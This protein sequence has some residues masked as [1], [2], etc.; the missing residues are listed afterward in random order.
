[1]KLGTT[2]EQL[3]DQALRERDHARA[4]ADRLAWA[5]GV[6]LDVS[7]GEHGRKFDDLWSSARDA[8]RAAAPP[9]PPPASTAPDQA[10]APGRVYLS[11]PMTG[12][13]EHNV[14]AFNAQARRLR[15]AGYDVVNPA[16]VNPDASLSWQQCLRQDMALLPTCDTL[17]LLPGWEHSDGAHLELHVAHRLGLRIVRVDELRMGGR[18][19]GH[20]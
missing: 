3:A 8:I 11:G 7:L 5:I 12:I 13:A 20:E 16:E 4:W 18:L 10:G 15:A 17:A 6:H 9:S 1:M 19:Y 14:P 2:W